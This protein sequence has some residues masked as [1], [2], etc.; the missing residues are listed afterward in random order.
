MSVN[1][2]GIGRMGLVVPAFLGGVCKVLC[3]ALVVLEILDMVRAAR[4]ERLSMALSAVCIV[5]D[6]IIMYLGTLLLWSPPFL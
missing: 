6:G 4:D 5:G 1:G 2:H 3:V